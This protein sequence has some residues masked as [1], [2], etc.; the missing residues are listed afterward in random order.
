MFLKVK[1]LSVILAI[2][3]NVLIL[4]QDVSIFKYSCHISH[5]TLLRLKIKIFLKTPM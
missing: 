3:F 2:F 5:I 4:K 1:I